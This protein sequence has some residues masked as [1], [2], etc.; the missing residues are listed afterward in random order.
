MVSPVWLSVVL[1]A[2]CSPQQHLP[3]EVITVE[4]LPAAKGSR[5]LELLAA[6]RSPSPEPREKLQRLISSAFGPR[7]DPFTR[8]VRHHGGIDIAV[9]TGTPVVAIGA[10]T[11]TKSRFGRGLGQF[12][13]VSH[14]PGV[15]S[16]YG[17]LSRRA[18]VEGQRVEA[19]QRLGDSGSTG[20][21]TGPHL[22]LEVRID[23]RPV[24]PAHFLGN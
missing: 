7:R 6:R 18:V 12:V 8:R 4:S 10:G 13:E 5:G 3:P 14:G 17:H 9:P 24:D 15:V 23:G 22:H 16:R 2:G 20:R 21:S 19:G 11:V 1:G